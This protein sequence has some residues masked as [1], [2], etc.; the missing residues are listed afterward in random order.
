MEPFQNCRHLEKYKRKLGMASAIANQN[1][2][3]WVFVDEAV[4][5]DII[6]NTNQ[7]V[8]LRL[9]HP[10][11][12]KDIITTFVYAKCDDGERQRLWEDLYHLAGRMKLP[13][14]VGGDFNVII[15]EE[16][17]LGG[18]PVTLNECKDFAFCIN[19]CELFDL[20]FKGSPFTWWNGRAADD[21]IF[22]RLDRILANP[23]FQGIFP[24][25]EVEHLINTGSDHAPLVLSCGEK[26][27][28]V[29]KPFRFLNF[30]VKHSSFE[31][32]VQ[33]N[34]KIDFV[35]S[36]YLDH[37]QKAQAELKN[38]LSLEE[39]WKQKD[40]FS[41]Y[42]KGDRNTKFF[43]NHVNGKRRRLQIN[44]ILDNNGNWLESKELICAEAVKF[45]KHHFSQE[46][47]ADVNLLLNHVPSMISHE[48]NMTLCIY[49]T[50]E[51]VKQ[52]VF[53]LNGDST[54]G[55]DGFTGIFYQKC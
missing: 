51:E 26:V 13:W 11:I 7:Q 12:S 45:F 27:T 20:G 5:W 6:M 36:P 22:K 9:N 25:I 29:L 30:W 44:R 10:D 40:G 19:S 50:K 2:K 24:Q 1:G 17:K 52:A 3:I 49:P 28:N 14:M 21:C 8:T 32:V 35:G 43:H 37:L 38:Y 33:E 46:D 15:S 4:Q 16:E 34:W 53:E 23:S 39:R 47:D 55:P 18:F 31:E 41:W 54:S 42:T 48:R